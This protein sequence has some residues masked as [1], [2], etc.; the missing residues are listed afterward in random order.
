MALKSP[1]FKS[2]SIPLYKRGRKERIRRVGVDLKSPL[3]PLYE[4]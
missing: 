3:I 4:R 1:S 2:P